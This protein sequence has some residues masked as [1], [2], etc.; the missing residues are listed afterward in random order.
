VHDGITVGKRDLDV[1]LSVGRE[2]DV[3][4]SVGRETSAPDLAR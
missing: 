4:P 2:T 3:V 1:V